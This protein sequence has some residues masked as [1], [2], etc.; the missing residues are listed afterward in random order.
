MIIQ[1]AS[2][3]PSQAIQ[4]D[5]RAHGTTPVKP[6][7]VTPTQ[8]APQPVSAEALSNAVATINQA[9]QDSN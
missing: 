9:M 7:S 5:M 8:A 2:L 6:V 4:P 1:P 3:P